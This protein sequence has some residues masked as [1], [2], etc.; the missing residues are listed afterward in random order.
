[1][2]V[3]LSGDVDVTTTPHLHIVF[4]DLVARGERNY[5]IDLNAVTSMDSSGLAALAGLYKRTRI[6]RGDVRLC[7]V[8]SEMR[9][10]IEL[11][12]FDRVFEIFEDRR[13][14][15]ASFSSPS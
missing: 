5:V 9:R 1:M 8:H 7:G 15:V 4:D 6:G 3:A 13:S 2:V 10:I 11:T 14:A 12:R